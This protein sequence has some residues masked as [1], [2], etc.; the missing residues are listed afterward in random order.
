MLYDDFIKI[1]QNR[2]T[3]RLVSQD[4]IPP[5]DIQKIINAG[6]FAPSADKRYNYKVYALSNS[7]E[8]K[9]K[10]L[11]LI[12]YFRCGKTLPND[13]YDDKELIQPIL[14]GLTLLYTVTLPGN[15]TLSGSAGRDAMIN[16]SF[17]MIAAELL[18]YKTAFLGIISDR[19]AARKILNFEG[20]DE[21]AILAVTCSTDS[22]HNPDNE[23]SFEYQGK[24]F[25]Y[26]VNNDR[27]WGTAPWDKNIK[28]FIHLKKHH[29][30]I[31]GPEVVLI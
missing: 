5:E 17:S 9:S 7:D 6:K 13:P 20:D 2:R 18:G 14:S 16:A 19:V 12:K 23:L 11:E 24:N 10:K 21:Y 26:D 30:K 29:N 8:G 15:N 31:A 3:A 27:A 22:F 4:D 1:L 28:M 25:L